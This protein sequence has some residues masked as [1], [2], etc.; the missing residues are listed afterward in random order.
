M[1][2]FSVLRAVAVLVSFGRLGARQL[3]V[4]SPKRIINGSLIKSPSKK[5]SFHALPTSTA[6][7]D[8]WLGC[9]ASIISQTFGM[10]AAHCFGG[11]LDPCSGPAR[12]ALWLGDVHL[13]D[14]FRITPKPGGKSF[15]VEAEVICHPEFDGK[16]S[17]GHDIVLLRLADA[18]PSWVEPV[19]VDLNGDASVSVGEL[20]TDIGYGIAENS[21]NPILI[22]DFT[23]SH[24]LRKVELSILADGSSTCDNV[25][26][27]GY[28]C[29]DEHSEGKATNIDQQICAGATDDPDRDTCSGDS[30]SP[31]LNSDGVQIGIVSYGG[32][33]GEKL[34][35]P[36]RICG[37]PNYPGV[38]SRVSAFKDFIEEHVHDLN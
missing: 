23:N 38:Y 32:G 15:R 26:K 17:H 9:G 20:T 25:Y 24:T 34:S 1:L 5:Y 14:N 33:P 16:C 11:G 29:S 21:R 6:E 18:L 10:S 8:S 37:D 27:G 31:M 3:H 12:L 19:S 30:G 22:D 4:A 36:G 13:A 2:S 35:G 28:G 7:S